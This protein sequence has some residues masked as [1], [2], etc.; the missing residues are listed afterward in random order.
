MM[1]YTKEIERLHKAQ[2]KAADAVPSK[3]FA[4]DTF[5]DMELGSQDMAPLVS[6][7]S[8]PGAP[9][10]V[11]PS[12]KTMLEPALSPAVMAKIG[13]GV[14]VGMLLPAAILLWFAW[15]GVGD[16]WDGYYL[17]P[18]QAMF[19]LVPLGMVLAVLS[20]RHVLLQKIKFPQ[21]T[22]MSDIPLRITSTLRWLPKT[23]MALALVGFGS[24]FL[25]PR[26]LPVGQ[27]LGLAAPVEAEATETA[28]A[29]DEAA[30]ATTEAVVDAP[31]GSAADAATDGAVDAAKPSNSSTATG[32]PRAV[33]L[34][35]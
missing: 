26:G 2:Q 10:F 32:V 28:V 16:A 9:Q 1:D 20:L 34:A 22:N 33:D 8:Q 18:F 11:A 31:T 35:K 14:S 13:Q 27:W 4:A 3:E 6:T 5:T 19:V 24:M 7:A 25:M 23:V 12:L 17:R 30:A 29:T 15:S 21:D